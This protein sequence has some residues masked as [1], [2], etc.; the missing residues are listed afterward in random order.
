MPTKRVSQQ[1]L[2]EGRTKRLHATDANSRPTRPLDPKDNDELNTSDAEN[3]EQGPRRSGRERCDVSRFDA[4]PVGEMGQVEP[5]F[6]LVPRQPGWHP[7]VSKMRC[8]ARNVMHLKL[9]RLP[10]APGGSCWLIPCDDERGVQ[11]AQLAPQLRALGWKIL[12]SEAH[13]V[14]L[15]GCKAGLREHAERHGLLEHLPAYFNG[16]DDARFPC[17]LKAATGVYGK[18]CFIV[19]CK[20]DILK[21]TEDGTLA[22][23]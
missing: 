13:V 22:S 11:V 7:M 12:T 4:K 5:R 1:P 6:H 17:V 15:L 8:A 18:D 2:A 14:A 19:R 16:P 3:V 9:K 23:V 10:R 20:E 21:V